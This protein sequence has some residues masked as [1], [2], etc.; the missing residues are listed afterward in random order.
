MST[1]GSLIKIHS[2]LSMFIRD[3]LMGPRGV[4]FQATPPLLTFIHQIRPDPGHK[5]RFTVDHMRPTTKHVSFV[6]W[7]PALGCGVGL[8]QAVEHAIRELPE[9]AEGTRGVRDAGA[10]KIRFAFFPAGLLLM[11]GWVIYRVWQID[12][13]ATLESVC[14]SAS[15]H[16]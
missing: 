7:A 14:I 10:Q 5:V 13:M 11:F 12:N 15:C 9:V 3:S 6:W 8:A 4:R 2:H 1:E 16:L